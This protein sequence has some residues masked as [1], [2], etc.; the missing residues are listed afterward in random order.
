MDLALRLGA[1][2]LSGLFSAGCSAQSAESAPRRWSTLNALDLCERPDGGPWAPQ[3]ETGAL[4]VHPHPVGS[5]VV[6]AEV[7]DYGERRDVSLGG[8]SC[9]VMTLMYLS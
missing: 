8:A 3:R 1:A 6:D 4:P 2:P 9:F 5:G 7:A